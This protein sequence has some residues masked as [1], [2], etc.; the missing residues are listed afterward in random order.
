[1]LK[2]DYMVKRQRHESVDHDAVNDDGRR[3]RSVVSDRSWS[4]ENVFTEQTK[5]LQNTIYGEGITG[6]SLTKLQIN[7]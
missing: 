4:A 5:G 1:M 7:R 6:N 3:I 2:E